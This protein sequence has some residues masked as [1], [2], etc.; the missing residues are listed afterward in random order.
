MSGTL[1]LS[2]LDGVFPLVRAAV[3]ADV[4]TYDPLFATTVFGD[5][6]ETTD[7]RDAVGLVTRAGK[8]FAVVV[9]AD[10]IDTLVSEEDYLVRTRRYEIALV[11][12]QPYTDGDGEDD[13]LA[14]VELIENRLGARA[15][16][17]IDIGDGVVVEF[18]VV[19]LERT[20]PIGLI[21][22]ENYEIIAH[23]TV[24]RVIL[25]VETCAE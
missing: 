15:G 11:I 9:V 5:S 6:R 12:V 16:F 10:D 24:R 25:E 18:R 7:D 22:N 1:H 14:R 8:P 19:G 17:D 20:I 2:D 3:A 4:R 13:F 23:R 21:P